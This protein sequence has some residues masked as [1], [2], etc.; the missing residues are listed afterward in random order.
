MPLFE[1]QPATLRSYFRIPLPFLSVRALQEALAGTVDNEASRIIL[2]RGKDGVAVSSDCPDAQ[3]PLAGCLFAFSVSRM[4]TPAEELTVPPP[5]QWQPPT[6]SQWPPTGS[7]PYPL[8]SMTALHSALQDSGSDTAT[9]VLL[10]VMASVATALGAADVAAAHANAAHTILDA[11]DAVSRASRAAG[12]NLAA[13]HDSTKEEVTGLAAAAAQLRP[14]TDRLRSRLPVYHSRVQAVP[15]HASLSG[16]VSPPPTLASVLDSDAMV[17]GAE[18]TWATAAEAAGEVEALAE[19]V[20]EHA[21]AVQAVVAGDT[22]PSS[23]DPAVQSTL[24][25]I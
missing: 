16:G 3:I 6:P 18:A 12:A 10:P 15:L 9:G 8:A 23:L 14:S 2:I 5:P 24:S 25:G 19:A 17:A 11:A 4:S 13:L 21:E 1:A 20:H 7:A 22:V